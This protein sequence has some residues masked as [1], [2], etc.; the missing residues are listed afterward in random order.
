MAPTVKNVLANTPCVRNVEHRIIHLRSQIE[1]LLKNMHILDMLKNYD[2]FACVH[3]LIFNLFFHWRLIK[4][5]IMP[6]KT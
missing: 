5:L 4:N 1:K 3:C 2:R 6:L